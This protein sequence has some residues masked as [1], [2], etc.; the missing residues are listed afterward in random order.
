LKYYVALAQE[1]ERMGAH[2][3]AIKDMAGLCKPYAAELLVKTLKQEVGIPIHF[4][5]HDMSGVQGASI[6]RAADVGLD[7][8]DAALAPMSGLTSQPNLNSLVEALRFQPRETGLNAENLKSLAHYWEAVREFYAPFET[9]MKADDPEIYLHEMPGGQATNL[10][11]QAA[12]LGLASHWGDVC[13]IYADVNQLFG[14]IVKVTPTSKAVGDMALF[15]LA[16]KLSAQDVLDPKRELAFPESVVDLMAGRMGQPPGGFPPDVQK[17]ILRD[18]K[19]LPGRPGATLPP[20]DFAGAATLLEKRLERQPSQREVLSHLLYPRVFEEFAA[21][22]QA[23]SDVSVLPTPT[24]LYGQEPGEEVA[25]EIESGK[26]LIIKFLTVGDPHPDGR[27]SVFFELNGQPREVTVVDR[28]L[29][30]EQSQRPQAD[31]NDPLQIAAP[32]PGLV[33]VVAVHAGD[34]IV[35]GQKLLTMEA[36]KMETTLYAEYEGRVAEVLVKP[37]TQVETGELLLRLERT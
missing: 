8:T 24:F 4:H 9:G 32:M 3:L 19:P 37:G 28:S 16:N 5:T 35:R 6:L 30:P 26:T 20:A 10:Y 34:A 7:I 18:Q 17:R 1:L 21:H 29:E 23:Y 15:L 31:P 36:M 13:R 22:E 27:R 33:V 25:V 2:I 11:Q 12:A 14:D